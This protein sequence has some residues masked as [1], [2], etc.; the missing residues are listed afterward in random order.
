M[1]GEIEAMQDGIRSLDT[2]RLVF[3]RAQLM[4][5]MYQDGRIVSERTIDS[6]IKKIAPKNST[7]I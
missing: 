4:D 7:T 2:S 6:H 3:T 1:Q 5:V